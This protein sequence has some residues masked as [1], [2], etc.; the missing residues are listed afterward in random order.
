[1]LYKMSKGERL[2]FQEVIVSVILSKKLYMY[3][4]PIPNGFRDR[5]VSLYTVQTSNKP[6]PHTS[7]KV[8]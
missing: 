1:M 5:A 8:H 2:V 6:C 3:V 7:C 4:Y